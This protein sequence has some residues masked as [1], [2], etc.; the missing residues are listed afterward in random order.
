MSAM[1]LTEKII[2][3]AANAGAV[4]PGDEVWATADRMIMND[5]SGPR[6]L[7]A[8]VDELGGLWDRRR[9]VVVSDHF[10]PAANLRHAEILKTTRTWAQRHGLTR[11]YEYQGILHNLVL[12]LRL[13]E[14]GMLLVGADSHTPAAG[15]VGAVAV[16]VGSTELATVLATG[17]VWL[18]VPE[19]IR[20]ELEGTLPALV[21]IRD[22]T[23]R[24]L[25]EH[26]TEF[27]L[28]CALEYAGPFAA[29]LTIEQRMVLANQGVEMGAKNALV[30][31]PLFADPGAG[32]RARLGYD[33]AELEPLVSVHPSPADVAP[34][35]A[36][37]D[38]SIDMAW[39]GSCVGGR[40]SDLRAAAGMVAGRRTAV[41]L[42]VT[43]ATQAIYHECV[44][45]GTL[46]TLVEAGATVLA[47]GCGACAGVHNGVQGPGDR[48][49]ATASRNFP[50]RM[51]SR[52]AEVYLASAYTVAASA[53]AGRIVD[54][55]SVAAE[56]QA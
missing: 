55:R 33:V 15:A 48:V 1:T 5:S 4:A 44:T 27:G 40:R 26:G 46:A 53:I 52:Q 18:R 50:G 31:A 20:I 24:I 45:D 21:D 19:T 11:F 22:L 8:L 7:G 56:T 28:Y 12:D 14:P 43:P 34:A 41:P 29:G 3:R 25:G 10:V 30:E 51:G 9:V 32:Y 37:G 23:T 6:R 49:I 39:L 17:Q 13:V 38:I 2:A 16:A 35:H 42:L 36:V 54:P 47:P